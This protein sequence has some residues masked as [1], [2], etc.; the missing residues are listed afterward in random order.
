MTELKENQIKYNGVI[1]DVYIKGR[2]PNKDND[3]NYDYAIINAETGERVFGRQ[4]EIAR[5]FIEINGETI[6]DGRDNT[7][8]LIKQLHEILNSKS[9]A[10]RECNGNDSVLQ[11]KSNSFEIDYKCMFDF[12]SD[13][14]GKL[15]SADP[16][17]LVLDGKITQD[18]ADEIKQINEKGNKVIRELGLLSDILM[19]NYAD[20]TEDKLVKSP[21][22]KFSKQN[23]NA[24][25]R[26]QVKKYLWSQLVNANY[27]ELPFSL[28]IVIENNSSSNQQVKVCVEMNE[29]RYSKALDENDKNYDSKIAKKVKEAKGRFD[30]IENRTIDPV[31]SKIPIGDGKYKRKQISKIVERD[32]KRTSD[33]YTEELEAGFELLI[34]YYEY[35]IGKIAS[36]DEYGKENTLENQD[37]TK[38]EINMNNKIGLNTILYGPP[39]TGKTYNTKRYVVAICD[40][41]TLDDVNK[42]NYESDILPRYNQLVDEGRVKFTTFHQSYGYE[43]FIEG[44]KPIVKNNNVIYDI[45]PGIFK[46][47]CNDASAD[48]ADAKPYVFVIDEINRGNIS[49]I[50]GEL[51]TLI[52]ESKRGGAKESMSAILPYSDELFSVPKNVFIL[53]TMNTAD[54]SIS[55][56]DTALRRRFDFVEMMPNSDIVKD[57]IV[58][59][60]ILRKCLI[61]S[62]KELL[63]YMIG[64][65]R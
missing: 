27:E 49:K 44:I 30:G 55:L 42:M 33:A 37:E 50:F 45:V 65:T 25:T 11:S 57:K 41:K 10:K 9:N 22:I 8:S 36:I 48:E 3:K 14:G 34:P 35:V 61:R 31:L 56:M 13:Y 46:K 29:N 7:H 12:I 28:S 47:F 19:E 17:K 15:Y 54:R 59:V 53:G 38:K 1:Y 58:L 26:S 20:S 64:S 40:N 43:E 62:M 51:I 23:K 24:K 32:D 16:D 18:E 21:P 6:K 2:N 39:G 60:L 63:F 5:I 52:E 4:K